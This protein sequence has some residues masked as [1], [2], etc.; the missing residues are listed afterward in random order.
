MADEPVVPATPEGEPAAAAPVTEPVTPDPKEQKIQ[1]LTEKVS[2]YEQLV[3][4][5]EYQAFLAQRGQ[6]AQPQR[7]E[8]SDDEKA[9]F[10]EKLNS[11]SRAEFAAFVRD[12]T[13]ETVKEQMFLPIQSA[14]VTE[15]VKDQIVDVSTKFPDFWDY[16]TEM[17]NISNSNP[18]L[19][20]EQVYHLAKAGRASAPA[21]TQA[22]PPAR[23]PGG[24][25]PSG[26]PA[27]RTEKTSTDFT[28]AF[29]TAFKKVGL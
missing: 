21:A 19:N 28:A 10:Q 4:T 29:E 23:K 24:E 5:P 6:Q 15:K 13:V 18:T 22:K 25:T 11:M 20:A 9:K 7:R 14:M 2:R 27:T 8:Y 17:I 16:R 12:L 1:E 26:P 3:V